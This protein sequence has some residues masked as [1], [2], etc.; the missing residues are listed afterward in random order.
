MFCSPPEPSSFDP[1]WA[2]KKIYHPIIPPSPRTGV[3]CIFLWIIRKRQ[4]W[5]FLKHSD[6]GY[7]DLCIERER[8]NLKTV[9]HFDNWF[10]RKVQKNLKNKWLT[11][12]FKSDRF[13]RLFSGTSDQNGK[14][15][16]NSVF[17]AQYPNLDTPH[18]YVSRTIIFCLHIG[19][20]WNFKVKCAGCKN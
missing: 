2:P 1:K 9:F 5:K 13:L 11:E 4:Q 14:Q 10:L 15:F 19:L 18:S 3:W 6:V 20:I 16:S 7:P 12:I 8:Q 17:P